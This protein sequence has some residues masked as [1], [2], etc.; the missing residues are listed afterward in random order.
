MGDTR[1]EIAE[2]VR[3]NLMARTPEERMAMASRMSVAA[4]RLVE[5]GVRAA[6]GHDATDADVY[7]GVFLRFYGRELGRDR[8]N[9]ICDAIETR[10]RARG[11]WS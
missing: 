11:E 2:R 1:P 6:L 8:A 10:R 5:D 9:A 3:A 7:R 4:R